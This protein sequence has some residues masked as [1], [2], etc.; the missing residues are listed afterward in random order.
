MGDL[1]ERKYERYTLISY[2]AS[3]MMSESIVDGKTFR[4]MRRK[5]ERKGQIII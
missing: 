1:K 4:R 3:R 5:A 2:N